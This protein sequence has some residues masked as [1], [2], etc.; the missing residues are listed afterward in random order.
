MIVKTIQTSS[1][2]KQANKYCTK[3][4]HMWYSILMKVIN[5]LHKF[6]LIAKFSPGVLYSMLNFS[7]SLHMVGIMTGSLE[8]FF[9]PSLFC[10]WVFLAGI[11]GRW[12]GP[13]LIGRTAQD[14]GWAV[15]LPVSSIVLATSVWRR[16]EVRGR[17][18]FS[19][20]QSSELKIKIN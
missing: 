6:F 11:Q 16:V 7:I 20:A 4:Q 1:N 14:R 19:V 15:K 10:I 18:D 13:A 12:K 9:N 2:N 8:A 5:N 3:I 17:E